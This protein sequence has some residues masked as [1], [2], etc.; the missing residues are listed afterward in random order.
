VQESPD[1]RAEDGDGDGAVRARRYA[2]FIRE[3]ISLHPKLF[4]VAVLGAFVFALCTVASSIGLRWVID[5]VILPRFEDGTVATSTVVAGCALIIGI[6]V[7]RALGVIVRRTFATAAMWRMAETLGKRVADRYV[8]QPA[9][10]HQRYPDGQLVARAGVDI[11]TTIDVMAPIPFATST[12][13]LVFVS[14]GWL[15][16]TDLV[17]GSVAVA[18][19]PILIGLNVVYERVVNRHFTRAQEALGEFSGA[20]HES[21]EGVQLVKAY[22]AEPRETERLSAM[23][24]EIRDARVHA[25]RLLA[26]F[27]AAL[28]AI[29]ALT[30]IAL[31]VVGALRVRSG[32]ITVGQ[33]SASVFMFT[34]LVWPL[35]F[36]GYALSELPRSYAGYRRVREVTDAPL[37]PDPETAIGEAAPGEAVALSHVSFTFPDEDEPTLVDTDIGIPS[38]TITAFVGATGSGKTTLVEL[39]S[40]LVAPTGGEVRLGPAT[41]DR[42]ARA[43]VFQEAFLFGGTV[44]DNVTMF[45]D[46]SDDEVWEA[47][48]LASADTFVRDLP[49]GLDTIVGE[50]GVTLSGGQ[51]QRVALARALVRKPALLLL[52]D[53][54]SALDP[55]TEQSVL[56]N[57]RTA[58]GG[59][60]VVMVA[61]RPS[62]IAL[63]D[64][65]VFVANGRVAAHGKH[66]EL[67]G[68]VPEYRELVEAFEADRVAG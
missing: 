7:I 43:I 19:F 32:D 62:T 39:L 52:D 1:A 38:G 55:S 61:S 18:V 63:A 25:V 13:L 35:R 47:L 11:D 12:V 27:E 28:E 49:S 6:G 15:L 30:N 41:R 2:G 3:L 58:L 14:A 20:V 60:T 23:A 33:L 68:D 9:S 67:M 31:V 59:T 42:R 22:G 53:T 21:F 57:L 65:V 16:W 34:L 36:F 54:T 51:R 40:G 26:N 5:H 45:D 29:P 44:R 4:T 48:R 56:A 37:D 46:F 17:V 50:R 8:D 64:D 66:A 24:G 10:W